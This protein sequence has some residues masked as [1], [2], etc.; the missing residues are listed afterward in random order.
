[1]KSQLKSSQDVASERES[2][3]GTSRE[4][5]RR[6]RASEAQEVLS[7]SLQNERC[8]EVYELTLMYYGLKISCG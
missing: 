6:E 2:E 4:I 1:M 7:M 5:C 3:N 8:E